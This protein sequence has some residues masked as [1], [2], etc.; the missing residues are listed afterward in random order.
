[1]SRAL[2]ISRMEMEKKK[3]QVMAELSQKENV[4]ENAPFLALSRNERMILSAAANASQDGASL[5]L[6]EM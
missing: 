2:L 1:L 5:D 3:E 6:I 4:E